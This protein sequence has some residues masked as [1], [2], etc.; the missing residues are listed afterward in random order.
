LKRGEKNNALQ[1][2]R[3]IHNSQ[4]IKFGSKSWEV[5][6]TIGLMSTI[7]MQQFNYKAAEKCLKAVLN[8]Q[9][10]NLDKYHPAISNTKSI[11]E[12]LNQAVKGEIRIVFQ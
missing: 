9:K 1:I 11:I 7:H 8:W 4:V 5:A 2:Y 10:L 3:S 6:E 12:K